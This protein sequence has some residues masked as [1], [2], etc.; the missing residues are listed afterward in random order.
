MFDVCVISFL[1]KVSQSQNEILVSS[2]LPLILD[3]GQSISI[4][5]FGSFKSP[6]KPTK[7]LTNQ[8]AEIRFFKFQVSLGF[9]FRLIFKKQLTRLVSIILFVFIRKFGERQFRSFL[10]RFENIENIRWGKSYFTIS[11]IETHQKGKS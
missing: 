11:T 6:K 8:R 5:N 3:K 4:W 7:F 10:W 9:Q 2:H 1:L